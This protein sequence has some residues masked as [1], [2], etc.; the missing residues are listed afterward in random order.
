MSRRYHSF[1]PT[2]EQQ[3]QQHQQQQQRPAKQH[4]QLMLLLRFRILEMTNAVT[5]CEG[6]PVER[7]IGICTN[8]TLT[9]DQRLM[10]IYRG[11]SFE[12]DVYGIE[13]FLFTRLFGAL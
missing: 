8:R 11:T 4:Q 1:S 3:Q 10:I 7:Y 5:R 6:N 2:F 13:Q 12:M 9:T